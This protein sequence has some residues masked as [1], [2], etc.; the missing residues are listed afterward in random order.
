M[1]KGKSLQFKPKA[2][3]FA[4]RENTTAK[5]GLEIQKL[6]KIEELRFMI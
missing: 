5:V 6:K 1:W 2:N 3:L 4:L